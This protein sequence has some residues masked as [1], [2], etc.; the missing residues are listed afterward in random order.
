MND[1][2]SAQAQKFKAGI[3]TWVRMILAGLL[4]GALFPILPALIGATLCG[5]AWTCFAVDYATAVALVSAVIGLVG[6]AAFAYAMSK[7]AHRKKFEDAP[8]R[9]ETLGDRRTENMVERRKADAR[10]SWLTRL[11]RERDQDLR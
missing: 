6:G 2:S 8:F 5:Y 1:V 9:P 11:G 4:V 7:H 10:I 3:G